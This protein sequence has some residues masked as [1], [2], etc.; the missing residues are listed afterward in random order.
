MSKFDNPTK[1]TGSD[2][3][4]TPEFSHKCERK[5]FAQPDNETRIWR[6]MDFTKYV[7]V[8]LKSG[9]FFCR[10]DLLNDR[11]EGSVTRGYWQESKPT[12]SA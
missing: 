11:F 8:L 10:C 1:R 5:L 4:N 3:P 7:A 9:L 12:G 6:Y 2:Q